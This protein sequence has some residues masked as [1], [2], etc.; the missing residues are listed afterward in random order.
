[1]NL[2]ARKYPIGHT[3]YQDQLSP[4]LIKVMIADMAALPADLRTAVG[5]LTKKQKQQSYREG[6]WTATQIIHHIADSHANCLIR[7][8]VTLTEDNPTVKPYDENLWAELPDSL[9]ENYE[10]SLRMVEGLH[11]RICTVLSSMAVE[12]F[13]R[14]Y[15]H[16][17]YQK[18]FTLRE[19]LC[20]YHWHGRH[21]LGQI[22]VILSDK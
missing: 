11:E 8:K 22:R 2:E 5:A 10:A 9:T 16:P 1:M 7:L 19:M 17:G 13:E 3:K 15:Y 14:T 6:G 4:E 18:T 12:D 21:H 20:L